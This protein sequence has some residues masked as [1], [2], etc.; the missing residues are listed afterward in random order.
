LNHHRKAPF[1]EN[2]SQLSLLL[3]VLAYFGLASA[4]IVRALRQ[5]NHSRWNGGWLVGSLLVPYLLTALPTAGADLLAFSGGLARMAAYLMVPGLVLM[6][7]PA[8]N[9]PLDLADL[10]AILALWLPVEFGWLPR[11]E[12]PVAPGVTLPIPLLTAVCLGFLLF[13]VIRPLEGLGYTFRL[14]AADGGYA[15]LALGA[16]AVAGIPLGLAMGFFKFGFA[17]FDPG[18]WAAQL[19]GIYFLTA[20]PE[21]LLFRGIIQNLIEQRFGRNWRTLAV[22][23]LVFGVSHVNNETAHHAPPNW[24]YVFLATL[25]GLAYG[26]VWRKS[27][28][29]TASALTHT[30][31]NF[32]WGVMLRG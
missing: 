28:K 23:A 26:W 31:V 2:M 5:F 22:A 17:P 18:A 7:R 8:R 29:I 11:A 14:G 27:G 6:F 12:A 9:Q 1:F 19:L 20:L 10:I 3:L 13:L 24:P 30:L 4:R 32:T 25:G 21:E 15:V 16:F